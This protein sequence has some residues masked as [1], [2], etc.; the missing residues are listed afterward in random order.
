MT[1]ITCVELLKNA[2]WFP[3]VL[4]NMRV[5]KNRSSITGLQDVQYTVALCD[6]VAGEVAQVIEISNKT[7]LETRKMKRLW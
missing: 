6:L 5:Q 1:N 4:Q 3:E 7:Q 2:Y